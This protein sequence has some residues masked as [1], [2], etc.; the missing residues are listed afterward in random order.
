MQNDS[1]SGYAKLIAPAQ[2]IFARWDHELI[3]KNFLDVASSDDAFFLNFLNEPYKIYKKT[4][5]VMHVGDNEE[6]ACTK[7]HTVLAILDMLCS[8]K[9]FELSGE[10]CRIA[11]FSPYV[12]MGSKGEA[13]LMATC[14]THFQNN[15]QLLLDA[16]KQLGG[17]AYAVNKSADI[18]YKINLFDF[19]PVIVQFWEADDEFPAQINTLWD[20][21]TLDY[22][23]FETIFYALTCLFERLTCHAA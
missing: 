23:L 17:T 10:W 15:P 5:A 3:C 12:D 20:K 18:S 19:F 6:E 21:N 22:L 16:C 7:P 13:A 8:A 14:G 1:A 2:D 4:G 11:Y 9:P